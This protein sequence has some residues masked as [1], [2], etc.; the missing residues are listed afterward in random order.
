MIT[1]IDKNS[2]LITI[3][4]L[5]KDS[6]LTLLA[7]AEDMES[8]SEPALKGKIMATLFF[9]PSTRTRL[10]FE[11][12]MLR[13]GGSVLGFSNPM[14][15]SFSKG[16]SLSDAARMIE[17]YC[18]V[19]VVR[20]PVEG[21]VRQI[22]NATRIPVINAGDGSNEHPT[23]TLADLY[24]IKKCQG[25]IDGLN[26]AMVGDLK[27]GRTVHS[28]TKAL[29][30]F[31]VKL[32]LVSP[33]ELRM[34]AGLLK[35]SESY[36]ESE[37]LKDIISKIDILYMTR[38]Q[39]ERFTDIKEYERLKGFYVLSNEILASAKKTMM[40]FHPLPRV[41]EIKEE[42]DQTP[43]AYYF[44]QAKNAVAMRKAILMKILG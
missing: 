20:N 16:E 26:I 12:A 6:I 5:S 7:N 13:L 10:S 23:Q 3:D 4:N 31:R 33:K 28:L 22:A 34:P 25:K 1:I 41:D 15:T 35:G 36:E 17:N 18:D 24:S 37:N 21:S 30:H 8:F 32:F 43:H 11:S 19:M 9:E 42:V 44:E 14:S 38:M 39:K 29:K 27:Y 2:D 40:I